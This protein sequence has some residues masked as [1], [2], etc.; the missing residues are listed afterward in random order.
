M[1]DGY[2]AGMD[3]DVSCE[4]C[5]RTSIEVDIWM[6]AEIGND[7]GCYCTDCRDQLRD[8]YLSK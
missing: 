6:C 1:F 7:S 5:G 4:R 8:D 3:E 2:L